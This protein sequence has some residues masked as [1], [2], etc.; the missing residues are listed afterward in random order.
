DTIT[1][2]LAR[3]AA[4]APAIGAPGRPPLSH[5]ALRALAERTTAS[6]NAMG[7]GRNDR[8]AMVLPNGPE[9]GAGF[10]AVAAGATA[11]PLTPAY[12]EDEF[13][14]Y[15]SDLNAKALVI[16]QGMESPARAVATRRS[17]PIIETVPGE[18]AGD[19]TLVPLAPLSGTPKQ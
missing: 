2:L 19:F 17:I 12:R 11:A 5:A 14:F 9:M 7:I 8:V 6:L 4:A 1:G 13:D 16:A 3:G 18:A 15:L 10:V